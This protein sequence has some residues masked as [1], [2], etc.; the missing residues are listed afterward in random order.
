MPGAA[1]M[2]LPALRSA[3][4]AAIRLSPALVRAAGSIVL[5]VLGAT[6]SYPLAVWAI[7]RG[8]AYGR[9]QSASDPVA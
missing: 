2:G 9:R 3:L 4:G 6:L 5:A 1:S 8:R 7:K